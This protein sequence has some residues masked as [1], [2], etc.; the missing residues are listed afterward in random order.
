MSLQDDPGNLVP[1]Q[2]FD[3]K[4]QTLKKKTDL[5]NNLNKRF[6]QNY[7]LDGSIVTGTDNFVRVDKLGGQDFIG[8]ASQRM[9]KPFVIY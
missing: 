5:V 7:Y 3:L 1:I 8:V 2:A 6:R 9:S 4:S